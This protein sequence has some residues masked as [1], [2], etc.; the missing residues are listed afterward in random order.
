MSKVNGAIWLGAAMLIWYG[1][2]R[3]VRSVKIGFDKLRVVGVTASSIIYRVSLYVHNTLMTDVLVNDIQGT[4]Y[5]MDI[6]VAVVNYPVNQL[7][8][9]FH[10]SAFDIQ[11][12]AFSDK[13]GEA[14]WTN[15]MT[16]DPHTLTIVF[17]GYV[18]IRNVKIPV[19][20][21]FTYDEIISQ[22]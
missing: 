19:R 12:E 21:Q 9:A 11:F 10:T 6:P 16:G 13:L 18:V 14:L 15:I 5:M 22:Q 20:K 7:I 1:F 8:K 17:D 2:V 3:G 4:I